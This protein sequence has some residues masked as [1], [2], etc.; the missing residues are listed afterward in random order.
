MAC[1][2]LCNCIYI[3][4]CATFL[5]L[6][7]FCIDSNL[8]RAVNIFAGERFLLSFAKATQHFDHLQRVLLLLLLLSFLLLLLLLLL[9]SNGCRC[10]GN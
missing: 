6:F 3:H 2:T 10:N 7:F 9:Q 8:Q 1:R 5:I 4:F